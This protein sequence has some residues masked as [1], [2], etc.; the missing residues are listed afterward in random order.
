MK[1]NYSKETQQEIVQKQIENSPNQKKDPTLTLMKVLKFVGLDMKYI[2]IL[3]ENKADVNYFSESTPSAFEQIIS[4]YLPKLKIEDI[5]FFVENKANLNS[6]SKSTPLSPFGKIISNYITTIKIEDLKFLVEHKADVNCKLAKDFLKFFIPDEIWQSSPFIQKYEPTLPQLCVEK[7]YLSGVDEPFILY[8]IE[9][10]ASLWKIPNPEGNRDKF[11]TPFT[12]N[13]GKITKKHIELFLKY[14]STGFDHEL[15]SHSEKLIKKKSIEPEALM[16][17]I[18]QDIIK[19]NQGVN[20]GGRTYRMPRKDYEEMINEENSKYLGLILKKYYDNK[21]INIEFLHNHHAPLD[22]ILDE[23]FS[24]KNLHGDDI[25]YLLEQKICHSLNLYPARGDTNH[26]NR[27]LQNNYFQNVK[28]KFLVEA[29][30]EVDNITPNSV[31]AICCNPNIPIN[32]LKVIASVLWSNDKPYFNLIL[33]YKMISI[34]GIKILNEFTINR[35]LGDPCKAIYNNKIMDPKQKNEAIKYIMFGDKELDKKDIKFLLEAKSNIQTKNSDGTTYIQNIY[36]KFGGFNLEDLNLLL[37]LEPNV[38]FYDHNGTSK[39]ALETIFTD[40][41][42]T[43]EQFTKIIDRIKKDCIKKLNSTLTTNTQ[44]NKLLLET[45]MA[46]NAF[47]PQHVKL[48]LEAK[49]DL[50]QKCHDSNSTLLQTY[51]ASHS[52]EFIKYAGDVIDQN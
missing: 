25:K 28:L 18:N 44:D 36:E 22:L 43:P 45:M 3:V 27:I 19:L 14:P 9:H 16:Y 33:Q 10:K 51:F 1:E 8:L 20:T 17:L 21:S 2:K 5:K 47:K 13:F 48:L 4:N 12:E 39:T 50:N 7:K 34:E 6:S 11:L 42:S 15:E 41:N 46:H 37:S 29:K 38:F 35:K 40:E 23:I 32:D 49:A 52:E 31:S 24:N 26:F 30:A